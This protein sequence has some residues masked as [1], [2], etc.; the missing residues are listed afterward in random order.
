V[1]AVIGCGNANR[2]DDG[3][4]PEVIRRLGTSELAADPRVRLLDAGTDGMA[5]MFAARDCRHLIV[6]DACHSGS[7]TGAVFEIPGSELQRRHQ[8]SM[9]LHDF[10]WEHALYAGSRVFGPAF[11]DRVTVFLVEAETVD[12]GIGLSMAAVAAVEN[13]KRRIE[14]VMRELL[15]ESEPAA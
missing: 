14:A 15:Q 4:G 2:M 3:I 5:V 7:E 13:V 9:T 8:A 6:V 1:I 11:P 12:F 10:R